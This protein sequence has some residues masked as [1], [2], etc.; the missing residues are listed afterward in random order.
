MSMVTVAGR[1]M[2]GVP[3]VAAKVFSAVAQEGISVLM[4]SQSSSE[5]SIC[6][7]VET[8]SSGRAISALEIAFERELARQ[9]IDR[10]IADDDVVIIAVVGAGIRSTPGVAAKVF[11]ALGR[12]SVNVISIA[13]GSSEHNLSLVVQEEDADAAV[14]HIHEEFGLG[15]DSGQ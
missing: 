7:V 4:I 15:Q 14:R 2:L 3:G 13:Q 12:N 8:P 10:I 9:D 1:G 11:G 5:Q 6:F